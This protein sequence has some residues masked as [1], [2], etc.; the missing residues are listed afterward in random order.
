MK[1]VPEVSQWVRDIQTGNGLVP[2]IST[3][4][5]ES[6]IKIEN[7]QTIVIGGL[8]E[9][10]SVND[11]YKLPILGS[12]PLVGKAF[13]SKNTSNTK[14]NLI[15]LLTAHIMDSNS[16]NTLSRNAVREL[17]ESNPLKKSKA[18]E[19]IVKP[20]VTKPEVYG[21]DIVL[22]QDNNNVV[23]VEKNSENKVKE[24]NYIEKDR[25]L[26]KE[27]RD[28]IIEELRNKSIKNKISA[29]KP[30]KQQ[31][32]VVVEEKQEQQDIESEKSSNTLE[33]LEDTKE[34][35]KNDSKESKKSD[36]DFEDHKKVLEHLKQRLEEVKRQ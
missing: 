8:I 31:E 35:I 5:A 7:G 11:I 26:D 27:E 14:T 18:L 17:N 3:R 23:S 10:K 15:I 21:K 25:V 24:N 34:L 16:N 13:R 1:V 28:K 6:T 32:K 30:E 2:Q 19:E 29:T 4:K 20:L 12:L 36:I 33:E 9:S 22:D